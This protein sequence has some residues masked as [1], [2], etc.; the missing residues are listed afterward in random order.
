MRNKGRDEGARWLNRLPQSHWDAWYAHDRAI[1]AAID[2]HIA[3]GLG[4]EAAY[5]AA[6]A[7]VTL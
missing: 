5:D 6:I 7:E 2:R 4:V 1:N 3:A